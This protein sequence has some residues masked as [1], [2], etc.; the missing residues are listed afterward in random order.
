VRRG[1]LSRLS[2]GGAS[3]ECFGHR[4]YGTALALALTV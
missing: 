4:M 3:D 2:A 1:F